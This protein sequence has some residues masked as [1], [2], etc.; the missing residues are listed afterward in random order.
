MI[1]SFILSPEIKTYL[2]KKFPVI[3]LVILLSVGSLFAIGLDKIITTRI[4][5]VSFEFFQSTDLP[6][7]QHVSNSLEARI[8]IWIT[9]YNTFLQHPIT[10]VGYFMFLEV[11]ENYNVFPDFIYDLYIAKCDAHTTYFNFLVDTG[12]LGLSAF[13]IFSITIFIISFKSIKISPPE[14]KTISIVLNVLMFH[15]IFNSI[16]AGSYNLVPSAFF[17]YSHFC[18][19]RCKQSSFKRKNKSLVIEKAF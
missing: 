9:A 3:I 1:I 4:S 2:K 6:S 10:G 13:L 7:D 19:S 8:L 14:N 15:M 18:F 17:F 12:I 16:Y 11:S 5:E